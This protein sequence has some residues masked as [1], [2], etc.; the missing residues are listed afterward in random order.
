MILPFKD[1][2][3][4]GLCDRCVNQNVDGV[5]FKVK[6]VLIMADICRLCQNERSEMFVP[7]QRNGRILPVEVVCSLNVCTPEFEFITSVINVQADFLSLI[8]FI[9]VTDIIIL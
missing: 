4:S 5:D 3:V 1:I 7:V 6:I 8:R 2:F 9:N